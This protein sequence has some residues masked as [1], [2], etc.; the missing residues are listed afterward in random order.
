MVRRKMIKGQGM[1][2]V[3]V[4]VP[5]AKETPFNMGIAGFKLPPQI[6]RKTMRTKLAAELFRSL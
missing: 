1:A 2:P 6:D 3:T 5:V 4:E